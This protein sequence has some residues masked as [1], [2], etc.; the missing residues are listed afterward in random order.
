MNTLKITS[1]TARFIPKVPFYSNYT[2]LPVRFYYLDTRR[3]DENHGGRVNSNL[4]GVRLAIGSR[5]ERGSRGER[6]TS[7]DFHAHALWIAL[8][9]PHSPP[10]VDRARTCVR[11]RDSPGYPFVSPTALLAAH[12]NHAFPRFNAGLCDCHCAHTIFS[13]SLIVDENTLH[14][15]MY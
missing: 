5:V 8:R 15:F 10:S 9:V 11:L 12:P 6:V 13:R 1:K 3:K 7:G 4:I 2:S 14:A